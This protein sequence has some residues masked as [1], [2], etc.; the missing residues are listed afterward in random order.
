MYL[1]YVIKKEAKGQTT[2]ANE[3]VPKNNEFQL[4]G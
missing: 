3:S 1:K 4:T 2:T